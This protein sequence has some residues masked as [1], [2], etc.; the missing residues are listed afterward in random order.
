M[1]KQYEQQKKIIFDFFKMM[2]LTN[3]FTLQYGLTQEGI[4][5]TLTANI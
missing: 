2:L 4:L 1:A 5:T 3:N